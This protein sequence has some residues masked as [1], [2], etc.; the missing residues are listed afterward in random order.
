MYA[1]AAD[2]LNRSA[3]AS[4]VQASGLSR[5]RS[6]TVAGELCDIVTAVFDLPSW[7]QGLLFSADNTD[8]S[9]RDGDSA[10]IAG[11]LRGDE[12]AYSKLVTRHQATIVA[13]MWRFSRDRTV[14]EELTHE[15][16]VEAWLSL[17]KYRAQAPFEHWLRRIAIRVGY[18]FWKRQARER[19]R[20]VQSLQDS[21]F[22]AAAET[23]DAR[24]AGEQV[25]RVLAQ[26]PPRDRLVLML[27]YL[28]Q[29]SVEEVAERIG[30][31]R[32][33]VRVQ[34]HRARKKLKALLEVED[35][36][37]EDFSDEGAA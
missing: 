27:L 15:V 10:K 5:R 33:M 23:S 1:F 18:R 14:M 35:A 26:L 12:H 24:D 37:A 21:D 17:S 31:T 11:A 36:D 25:H 8:A 32:T 22:A 19:H 28:D 29:C 20:G 9:D 16:F 34:A 30:W 4:L 13:Q 2:R 3:N 6:R 7:W